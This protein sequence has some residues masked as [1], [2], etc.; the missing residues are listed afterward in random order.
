MNNMEIWQ[1]ITDMLL[2]VALFYLCIKTVKVSP[3]MQ[4]SILEGNLR[5]MV[6]EADLATKTL[7]EK[8]VQRQNRLEELLIDIESAENRLNKSKQSIE[9]AKSDLEGRF[10]KVQRLLQS[11]QNRCETNNHPIANTQ[12]VVQKE[13]LANTA[14]NAPVK[15]QITPVV[16]EINTSNE[17][18][19]NKTYQALESKANIRR[20]PYG[21]Y[22][23]N[24]GNEQY[25]P[26]QHQEDTIKID[27][28]KPVTTQ[29]L[30][31]Q[32]EKE[33][34][35][36]TTPT[37]KP[38]NIQKSL[39]N[40]YDEAEELLKRGKSPEYVSKLLDLQIDEVKM[41]AQ[42]L[43]NVLHNE[44]GGMQASYSDSRLG[45]LDPIKRQIQT[46]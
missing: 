28:V 5:R 36:Q 29:R 9:E 7:Q 40:I 2:V 14:I 22:N 11:V 15:E 20:N 44:H 32:I 24:V 12:P 33:V 1:L 17:L 35:Q 38:Y 16:E 27:E 31:Q 41:L 43:T 26:T 13:Y 25:I 46:I 42:M 37:Q 19:Q 10:I 45:A 39:D 6:Q 4:S 34:Y 18:K 23:K 3:I 30:S 21:K 8:L